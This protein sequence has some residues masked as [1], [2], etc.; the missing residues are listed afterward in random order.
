MSVK[1]NQISI[2]MLVRV[3]VCVCVCLQIDVP[4][5]NIRILF[6]IL[7]SR[8]FP[9]SSQSFTQYGVYLLKIAVISTYFIFSKILLRFHFNFYNNRL[10]IGFPISNEYHFKNEAQ[11]ALA[12]RVEEYEYY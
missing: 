1:Y 4:L 9:D 7:C 8:L 6:L 3:C 12:K 11:F 10:L 2:K 5:F